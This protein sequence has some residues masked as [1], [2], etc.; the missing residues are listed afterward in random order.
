MESDGE[1]RQSPE[2]FGQEIT[3]AA[4]HA[5]D[6]QTGAPSAGVLSASH[7]ACDH[8]IGRAEVPSTSFTERA[9][10]QHKKGDA[11]DAHI[12]GGRVIQ[13]A[14]GFVKEIIPYEDGPPPTLHRHVLINVFRI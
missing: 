14:G 3:G 11:A 7:A 6:V 8:C 9:S 12:V 5:A 2:S 13:A 4:T 10:G 1:A